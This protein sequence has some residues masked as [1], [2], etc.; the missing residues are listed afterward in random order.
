[1]VLKSLN[2]GLRDWSMIEPYVLS[3]KEALKVAAP[4][5]LYSAASKIVVAAETLPE[6]EILEGLNKATIRK[7]ILYYTVP[8]E[9][10]QIVFFLFLSR[11]S[12]EAVSYST[13]SITLLLIIG[14]AIG[15][16]LVY[17]LLLLNWE[18][19]FSI[20][21]MFIK[22]KRMCSNT[23]SFNS[24]WDYCRSSLNIIYS[25]NLALVGCHRV[26]EPL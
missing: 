8:V 26:Q 21:D 23:F 13:T 7:L 19:R 18:E 24:I 16:Y 12:P 1:M 25:G 10:I 2:I 20:K 5:I 4:F 22:I 14:A 3:V 9:L 17:N 6:K 15:S 11:I